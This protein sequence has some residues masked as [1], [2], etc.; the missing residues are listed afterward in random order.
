VVGFCVG[1][2][3]VEAW[4]LRYL[5]ALPFCMSL[6]V[7]EVEVCKDSVFESQTISQSC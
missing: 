7:G 2:R 3:E 6:V 4:L 5:A 1:G